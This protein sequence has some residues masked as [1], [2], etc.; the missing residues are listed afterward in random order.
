[1]CSQHH[2]VELQYLVDE[3][4]VDGFKLDAGD[5]GFYP[6]WLKSHKRNI[7]PNEHTELFAQIGL[8]FPLNEYRATWKMAGLPLAQRLRDKGHNWEDLQ[9]LIPNITVQGLMGYAFTCPDMIGGGEFNSFLNSAT[10]DQELIVRSAQV[11]ALMPMMQFS[12]AP[13]RILDNDHLQAVKKAI[14]LR[15]KFTPEILSLVEEAAKSGEP[16]VRTMEYVFPQRG[17]EKIKFHFTIL[18][19]G[20]SKTHQKCI[21]LFKKMLSFQKHS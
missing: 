16:I 5:A 15:K 7:L 8:E 17:Q 4:G 1:M 19:F 11:H 6:S 18:S 10:I 13:W 20:K 9:T 12:V 21:V 2:V 14:E 3:Y